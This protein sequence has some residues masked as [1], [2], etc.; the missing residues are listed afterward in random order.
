MRSFFS[1]E[2]IVIY[3]VTLMG[4]MGVGLI[5]PVLPKI[6]SAYDL[7]AKSLGLIITLYTLPGILLSIPIGIMADRFGRR[8]I[9]LPA[10]LIF[11]IAGGGCFFAHT[12]GTLLLM[13]FFQGIGGSCL[14]AMAMILIGDMFSEPERT[15]VMG[16]NASILSVGT[17]IFP[18]LG[19]LLALIS[20]KTPFF[21]FFVS[22]PVAMLVFRWI[23]RT[24]PKEQGEIKSYFRGAG[25]YIFTVKAFVLYSAC[26][27]IFS[28][29]YGYFITF[30]PIF[31]A[32]KFKMNSDSIGYV[33]AS[34]AITTAIISARAGWFRRLFSAIGMIPA[35]FFLISLALAVIPISHQV[36]TIYAASLIFGAGMGMT[37]PSAQALITG[38][39]PTSHRGA[40]SA[41]YGAVVRLGQTVGPVIAAYIWSATSPKVFYLTGAGACFLMTLL[42]LIPVKII[43][44]KTN[45][46]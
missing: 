22:V 35:G 31:L 36:W 17:G 2:L 37:V 14:T 1:K 7:S 12:Y 5:A 21:L 15:S 4:V 46:W 24:V 3:G 10:L 41:I 29:L 27:V 19:G 44:N 20:W 39:S 32:L 23:P 33:I 28:L 11:G 42:F 45:D 9:L 13:R 18:L 30:L 16:I 6:E 43:N 34:A 25:E 40:M 8:R 38:L 26:A